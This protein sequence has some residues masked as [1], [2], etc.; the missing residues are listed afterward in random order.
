MC[1]YSF[2]GTSYQN[3]RDD[4]R[5]KPGF[6][7]VELL[8][9][10]GIIALLISVLLPALNKA[11]ETAVRT[12]CLSNVRQMGIAIIMYCNDN[13]GI[14]PSLAAGKNGAALA[15]NSEMLHWQLDNPSTGKSTPSMTLQQGGVYD[16][17]I[18]TQGIGPYLKCTPSNVNMLR[19]PSDPTYMTRTGFTGENQSYSF[20][21][22]INWDFCGDTPINTTVVPGGRNKITQVSNPSD[23]ILVVEEDERT[24]DDCNCSIVE[25]KTYWGDG[26]RLSMRHD[27]VFG[28]KADPMTIT[29]PS[30]T[31]WVPN[32]NGKGNVSFV[33]GH[34][35]N[36]AR[37]YAS[38]AAHTCGN[39]TDMPFPPGDITMHYDGP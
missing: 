10:I 15:T 35:E 34:A 36:V 28:K 24:L 2:T 14:F 27:P 12:K 4:R 9:V 18:A 25:T 3:P 7:L 16:A 19:C 38:L 5:V 8:V 31:P 6:T 20:S 30:N 26:N 23:K 11:R 17:A 1:C 39:V 22:S 21:Y 37:S 29:Y 33:D 13:K 32:A